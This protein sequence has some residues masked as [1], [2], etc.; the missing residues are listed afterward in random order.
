MFIYNFSLHN[1]RILKFLLYIIVSVLIV[2]I[3]F[4]TFSHIKN[5]KK[6]YVTDSNNYEEILEIKSANF[7]NFLKDSHDNIN[8][9]VGKNFK[10]IGFV[11]RLYDFKNNQFVLA[12]E[13]FTGPISGGS[14]EVVVV[15]IMCESDKISSYSDKTWIEIEGTI[16]KGFYHT[17][18]PVVKVTNITPTTCP[19]PPFV[20]PP[21]GG[22]AIQ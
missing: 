2:G 18:I 5:C 1:N 4:F 11:H 13:M 16:E 17:D 10:C 8:S 19:N 6:V 7:T 3:L 15:G 20:N 12:R 22:Y 21:D 14:A 9:Y